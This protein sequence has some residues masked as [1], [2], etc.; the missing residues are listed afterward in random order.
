MVL[1]FVQDY[2]DRPESIRRE[3]KQKDE[4]K[5]KFAIKIMETLLMEHLEIMDRF[6]AE[7]NTNIYACGLPQL[8]RNSHKNHA[9]P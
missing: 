5:I 2:C 6:C 1:H 9:R 8:R 3:E 7:R 4:N